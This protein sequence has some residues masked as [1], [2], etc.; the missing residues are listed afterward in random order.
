[1]FGVCHARFDRQHGGRHLFEKTYAPGRQGEKLA[2]DVD[3]YCDCVAAQLDVGLIDDTG[4]RTG[5]WD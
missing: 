3:M 2:A 4:R 1:M 5:K